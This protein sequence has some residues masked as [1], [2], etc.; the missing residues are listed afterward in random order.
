V[1]RAQAAARAKWLNFMA[2]FLDIQRVR[3]AA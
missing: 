2:C 3:T 1:I